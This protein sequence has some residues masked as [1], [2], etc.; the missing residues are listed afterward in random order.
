M[1]VWVFLK[2]CEILTVSYC[3]DGDSIISYRTITHPI[4]LLWYV[5][6][7]GQFHSC[8]LKESETWQTARL[9]FQIDSDW[10]QICYVYRFRCIRFRSLKIESQNSKRKKKPQNEQMINIIFPFILM[11]SMIIVRWFVILL[12][13]CTTQLLRNLRLFLWWLICVDGLKGIQSDRYAVVVLFLISFET[14]NKIYSIKRKPADTRK[15]NRRRK[16]FIIVSR[17]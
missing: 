8:H 5:C 7:L 6:Y 14:R 11:Q 12:H 16:E 1:R 4:V 2:W 10:Y 15:G 17:A 3:D 13:S 9:T